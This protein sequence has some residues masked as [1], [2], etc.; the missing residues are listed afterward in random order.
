MRTK[1]SE[2]IGRISDITGAAFAR[3]SA[4]IKA[5]EA[6]IG[7][8]EAAAGVQHKAAA[9]AL[10]DAPPRPGEILSVGNLKFRCVSAG[11]WRA[12]T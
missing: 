5:L 9:R 12:V 2:I 11:R 4:R 8:L 6:R 7:S 10:P 1:S 3:Q